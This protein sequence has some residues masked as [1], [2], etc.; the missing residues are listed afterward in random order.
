MEGY[1]TRMAERA[2]QSARAMEISLLTIR[3]WRLFF[4]GFCFGGGVG[5]FFRET[6]DAAGSVD[7]LLLAGEKRMAAGTNFDA[8]GVAFY[9]RTRGKSMPASAMHGYSVIVGVN[10]GFHEAPIHRVRS[11]RRGAAASLGREVSFDYTRAVKRL[12]TGRAV[13]IS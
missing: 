2:H 9:G 7:E 10:A 3:I 11:A 12:R 6:L 1:S 5:I 8:Q 4:C 13:A